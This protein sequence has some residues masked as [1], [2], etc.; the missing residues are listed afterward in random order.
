[1]TARAERH[2]LALPVRETLAYLRG[3]F[4]VTVPEAVLRR[5]ESVRPA[6][7]TLLGYRART[8]APERRGPILAWAVHTE[9]YRRLLRAGAVARGPRGY[10]ATLRRTW[11]VEPGAAP[12]ALAVLHR[13]RHLR[14]ALRSRRHE[15]RGPQGR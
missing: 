15:P 10:L 3:S 7:S 14:R 13:L 8:L 4:G 5:L 12:L 1:L 9:N 2:G 11:K 6:V